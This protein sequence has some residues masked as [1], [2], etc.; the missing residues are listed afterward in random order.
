MQR[1]V[2]WLMLL[3]LIVFAQSADDELVKVKAFIPDIVLDLK[4]NTSNNFAEQKL[5]STDE[6][7]LALNVVKQLKLVQDSLRLIR[8]HDGNSYP[9]GLGL[10]IWDGYRPRAVQYLM[11]EILPDPTFVADPAT[12]SSHNRGAAVDVT[13]IDRT[14]GEELE[15]PTYFDDF[16]ERASHS[17][18]DLPQNVMAN[19]ELL[20]SIMVD[21]GGFVI[22]SAEWWH[23]SLP[24]AAEFPLLDFQPK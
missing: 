16:S 22:Y 8:Q 3:P 14:T 5:Y 6:C 13:L 4:Y 7:F 15:M 11:W 18:S 1:L 9:Q 23:Y 19:R 17:Y 20:E 24:A 10:K 2:L 21:V 12:G